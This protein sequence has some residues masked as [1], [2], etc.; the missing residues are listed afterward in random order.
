MTSSE[1]KKPRS[2]SN[3]LL[4]NPCR[5]HRRRSAV[6]IA[7]LLC[8][9]TIRSRRHCSPP[10][11]L[12]SASPRTILLRA[13]KELT[14]RVLSKLSRTFAGMYSS[15]R[16]TTPGCETRAPRVS[17]TWSARAGSG[18]RGLEGRRRE[19]LGSEPEVTA[20]CA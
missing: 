13:I 20:V 16:S 9:A 8:V 4:K 15:D 11:A 3:R 12:R 6:W 19:L 18:E 14:E 17:S 7:C 10:S 1:L 5:R 2:P